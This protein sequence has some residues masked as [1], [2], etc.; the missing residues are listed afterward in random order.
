MTA[1]LLPLHHPAYR[2]TPDLWPDPDVPSVRTGPLLDTRREDILLRKLGPRGWGRLHHFRHFYSQGWGEQG[3]GR[4][5]SPRS[6]EAFLRFIE[7][8]PQPKVSRPKLFLTDDGHLELC[9]RDEAGLSVQLE[10]T[11]TDTEFYLEAEDR[12]GSVPH[13]NLSDLITLLPQP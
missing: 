10:F 7:A 9:W 6:L 11:P 3:R 1:A 8:M 4:P 13:Q 2:P 12:E 5:L